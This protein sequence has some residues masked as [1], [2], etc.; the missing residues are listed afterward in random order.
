MLGFCAKTAEHNNAV[1]MI[2]NLFIEN[3]P[4]F[5]SLLPNQWKIFFV[6]T[7]TSA[8]STTNRFPAYLSQT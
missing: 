4:V 5:S 1:R 7:L 6:L 3:P 8:K 2:V